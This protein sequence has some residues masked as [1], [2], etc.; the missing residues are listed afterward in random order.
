[1]NLVR[2]QKACE[3]ES[4]QYN[5]NGPLDEKSNACTLSISQSEVARLP[6][7]GRRSGIQEW[8]GDRKRFET[9]LAAPP[10]PCSRNRRRLA[11]CHARHQPATGNCGI[12]EKP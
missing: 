7:A 5:L 2:R 4:G 1:M 8:N 3:P 11:Q 10:D 12:R 6:S 9:I